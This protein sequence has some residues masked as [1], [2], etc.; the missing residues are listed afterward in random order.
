MKAQVLKYLEQLYV[1]NEPE[2]IYFKTLFHIFENYLDE[3]Q[4]GGLLTEQTGFFESEIC[5]TSSREM[6]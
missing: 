6:V 4:K 2:F 1:E 5:F 3:Q